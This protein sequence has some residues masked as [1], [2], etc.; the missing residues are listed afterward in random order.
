MPSVIHTV[1]DV[2][3]VNR[4]LPLNYVV[5]EAVDGKLIDS[6]SRQQHIVI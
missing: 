1:D 6:L 5:R 2:F 3:G 4:D